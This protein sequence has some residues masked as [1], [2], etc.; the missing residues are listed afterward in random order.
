[1]QVNFTYAFL[2]EETYVILPYSHTEKVY[3]PLT[4]NATNKIVIQQLQINCYKEI[5]KST[6]WKKDDY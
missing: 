2:Y 6:C 5:F 1:M 3:S 4:E